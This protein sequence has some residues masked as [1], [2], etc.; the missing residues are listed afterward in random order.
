MFKRDPSTNITAADI[1]NGASSNLFYEVFTNV[2]GESNSV[3]RFELRDEN[4]DDLIRILRPYC[5]GKDKSSIV[6]VDYLQ[7]I[8][9]SNDVKLT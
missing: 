3:R 2:A 1:R 4:V 8:P 9:P 6:C 5:N 7:I